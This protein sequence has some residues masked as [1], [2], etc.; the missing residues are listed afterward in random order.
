M[1]SGWLCALREIINTVI[2][3]GLIEKW[4]E[5][6][7]PEAWRDGYLMLRANGVRP[8]DAMLAVWL[9]CAIDDRGDLR[10][11]DDFARFMGVC[12][13]VTYQWEARRPEIRRWSELLQVMR[14]RGAR[15]AQ[16]DVATFEAA[17][18]EKGTAADRKLYYQRAGV[19]EDE[20]RVHLVGDEDG[21]VDVRITEVVVEMPNGSVEG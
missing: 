5:E 18:G 17:V 9:S 2:E 11:R 6:N 15:L 4:I 7:A 16:V 10:S 12:R 13:A 21:P 19:W 8:N 1:A 14:M 3:R 20:S